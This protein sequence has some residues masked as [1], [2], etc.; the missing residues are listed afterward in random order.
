[1]CYKFALSA[2][3]ARSFVLWEA[4]LNFVLVAAAGVGVGL[5]VGYLMYLIHSK[6]VCDPTIEVSLTFLT[7]LA[8]YLLAEQFHVS[9]V[10]A[11]VTT[12]L[13]LCFKRTH[14]YSP[15]ASAANCDT[16]PGYL[17]RRRAYRLGYSCE[18]GGDSGAVYLGVSFGQDPAMVKQAHPRNGAL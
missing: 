12:G 13:Y 5:L 11:V 8:S 10:L 15:R 16:G 4:G 6:F 1:M 3:T 18:P 7:P 14:L 17:F 9:G 2:I